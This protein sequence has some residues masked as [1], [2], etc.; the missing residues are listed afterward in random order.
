M[1]KLVRNCFGAMKVL[2]N[3]S[4]D[5]IKWDFISNLAELQ[6]VEGLHAATKLRN[7]HLQW[8][9]EVMKVR[10]AVQTISRSVADAITFLREN[11]Q[12]PSF[13]VSRATSEF[14]LKFNN[15]FDIFN[16]RGKWAKNKFKQNLS[17]KTAPDY[18]KFLVS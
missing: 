17:P 12:H 6:N 13:L 8:S 5:P 16:S 11:I 14:I 10:L 1:I 15:L 18:K 3:S 7:R 9:R 4:N 2:E